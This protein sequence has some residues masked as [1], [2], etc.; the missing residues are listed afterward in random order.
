MV[1]NPTTKLLSGDQETVSLANALCKALADKHRI[2][3][4]GGC[5][6]SHEVMGVKVRLIW[7]STIDY[8]LGSDNWRVRFRHA[9]L[10][11]SIV[12]SGE[13]DAF[14]TDMTVLKMVGEDFGIS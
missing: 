14:N 12:F 8:S 13:P 11:P 4:R 1:G 6:T 3:G 7:R 9:P 5:I 2:N 10:E